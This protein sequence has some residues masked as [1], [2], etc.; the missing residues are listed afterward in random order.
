MYECLTCGYQRFESLGVCEV[1]GGKTWGRLVESDDTLKDEP[2]DPLE[3]TDLQHRDV[4]DS[5]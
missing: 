3:T 2:P 4:A 1:C 5:L